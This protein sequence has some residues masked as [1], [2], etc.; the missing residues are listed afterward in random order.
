MNN[1]LAFS[2]SKTFNHRLQVKIL[3][4]FLQE[5]EKANQGREESLRFLYRNA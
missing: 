4:G 2:L 5:A 1:V 3:I